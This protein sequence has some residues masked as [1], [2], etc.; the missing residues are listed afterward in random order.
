MEG[1]LISSPAYSYGRLYVC[2]CIHVQPNYTCQFNVNS[3]LDENAANGPA[4]FLNVFHLFP[5]PL[6]LAILLNHFE[7]C[8]V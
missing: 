2:V 6:F 4:G 5:I 7:M 1:I 8:S 3:P